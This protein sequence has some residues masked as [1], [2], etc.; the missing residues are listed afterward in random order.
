MDNNFSDGVAW[1]RAWR[2]RCCPPEHILHGKVDKHLQEHLR[3]CPWCRADRDTG[4]AGFAPIP[5]PQQAFPSPTVGH[6]WGIR[7]DLGGWGPKHRYYSPPVVMIINVPAPNALTV[8]QTYDDLSFAG[9]DDLRLDNGFEGFAQPWNRYTIKQQDLGHYFGSVTDELSRRAREF[10]APVT[11]PGVGSL[12]W[13]FRQME[14]ET[15]FYFSSRAVEE[16]MGEYAKDDVQLTAQPGDL[17]ASL[18]Y[19]DAMELFTDIARLPLSVPE[20]AATEYLSLVHAFAS[21]EPADELLPKAAADVG[22]RVTALCFSLR[23]GRVREAATLDFDIT[24][25]D[26]SAGMLYVNGD[27]P[28]LGPQDQCLFF[29]RLGETLLEPAPG[30]AGCREKIFW[31]AFPVQDIANP[32]EG[33]L[34]VRVI[35]P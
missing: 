23:G 27:A 32:M 1:L 21:I 20:G 8:V 11:G 17:T 15:G 22:N 6:I 35:A 26:V 18:C 5:D 3:L 30:E 33:E 34:V 25:C 29:W 10:P 19:A 28:T 12:L 9:R 16:L 31:A 13:F 7:A 2:L 4:P 24:H 14:V